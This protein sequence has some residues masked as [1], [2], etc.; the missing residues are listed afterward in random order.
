MTAAPP[1]P[2]RAIPRPPA[3]SGPLAQLHR[4][5]RRCTACP[6]AAT[7]RHACP[8]EGPE[9]AAVMVVGEAPGYDEDRAGRPFVGRAGQL[10]TELMEGA[11][12][13]RSRVYIANTVRCL[14][15]KTGG[16]AEPPQEA[17]EACRMFL[18]REIA[19]V[20]PA[21]LVA[22]GRAALRAL[23]SPKLAISDAH[24]R[25]YTRDGRWVYP[26]YHPSYLLRNG[27]DPAL[28]RAF[29]DDMAG[30]G[31]LLRVHAATLRP[32]WSL[33]AIAWLYR[34][35]PTSHTPNAHSRATTLHVLERF[36]LPQVDGATITWDIR[37]VHE[38]FRTPSAIQELLRRYV[39][40]PVRLDLTNSSL[41]RG[42]RATI[43]AG[44]T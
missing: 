19:L 13:S 35:A 31:R 8:G 1:A 6:L 18:E 43:L 14:P 38:M 33:E 2:V 21:V 32:R 41:R 7:R 22:L 11:G 44:T 5:I 30:L 15:P 40:R 16:S 39:G 17:V 12:L 26:M 37:G 9:R 23:V 20:R 3:P 24:G 10:L 29:E 27:N 42:V 25:A 36:A 28:R 34:S 4:D